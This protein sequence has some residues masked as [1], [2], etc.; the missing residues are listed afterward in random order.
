MKRKE[1]YPGRFLRPGQVAD[2]I[3]CEPWELNTLVKLKLIPPP[4]NPKGSHRRWLRDD[5]LAAV[6]FRSKA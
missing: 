1:S 3:E 5:V 2:I 4:I 6:K